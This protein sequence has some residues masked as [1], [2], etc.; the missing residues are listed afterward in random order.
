MFSTTEPKFSQL[1][2]SL[3]TKHILFSFKLTIVPLAQTKKI[4]EEHGFENAFHQVL[5]QDEKTTIPKN[6]A[7]ESISEVGIGTPQSNTLVLMFQAR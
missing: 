6:P 4:R 5:E 3:Q 2:T 1:Q 7:S